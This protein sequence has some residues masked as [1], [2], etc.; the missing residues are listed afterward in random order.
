MPRTLRYRALVALQILCWLAMIWPGALLANRITP[1]V[2]GL[3]FMY[4]WYVAWI[5]VMTIGL[6]MLYRL[7][8]G[9]SQE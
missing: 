2:L 5:L 7:E 8:D 6:F 4:F 1:F 9:D 3:P